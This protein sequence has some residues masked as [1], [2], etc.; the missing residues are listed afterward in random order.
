MS[1]PKLQSPKSFKFIFLFWI[2]L[3]DYQKNRPLSLCTETLDKAPVL[4]LVW[5]MKHQLIADA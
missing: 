3:L 5:N 4:F 2:S 1:G